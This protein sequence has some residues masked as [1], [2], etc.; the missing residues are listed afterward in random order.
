MFYVNHTLL[1]S[2]HFPFI[3]CVEDLV[4]QSKREEWESC[5]EKLDLDSEPINQCYNSEHGK[6][7]GVFL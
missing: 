6:Q 7:V 1:Q 5:F 4:F 3:Y 2:K